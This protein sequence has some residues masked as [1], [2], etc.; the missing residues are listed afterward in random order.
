[1][2][3]RLRV[4]LKSLVHALYRLLEFLHLTDFLVGF[5]HSHLLM[6]LGVTHP[7]ML[8]KV[9]LDAMCA[10]VAVT[11][12]LYKLSKF[13]T[14][15]STEHASP[16][17]QHKALRRARRRSRIT[18]VESRTIQP[19]GTD[20]R[21]RYVSQGKRARSRSAMSSA[22]RVW[23][24]QW[25]FRRSPR[26]TRRCIADAHF[27]EFMTTTASAHLRGLRR[28]EEDGDWMTFETLIVLDRAT[29]SARAGRYSA[30]LKPI[31]AAQLVA[32]RCPARLLSIVQRGATLAFRTL[33]QRSMVRPHSPADGDSC[34]LLIQLRLLRNRH[35]LLRASARDATGHSLRVD[36]TFC[37]TGVRMY[38][39]TGMGCRDSPEVW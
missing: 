17:R 5:P 20:T 25:R 7:S 24:T 10:G 38:V 2:W 4:S 26:W 27:S 8:G 33:A 30:H 3:Y 16:N 34:R 35:R 28:H 14:S 18:I 32:R 39:R 9:S 31:A 1:M 21:K 36:E 22:G 37:L 19:D 13:A 29:V 15:E 11:P 12:L 6:L 23:M